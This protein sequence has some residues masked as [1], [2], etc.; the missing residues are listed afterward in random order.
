MEVLLDTSFIL[1]CLKEKIDFLQAGEY[2]KLI[3]PLQVI[4]ELRKKTEKGKAKERE[5]AKLA[6][7]IIQENKSNFKIIKLEKKFV[8]AG[9]KKYVSRKKKDAIVA[10]LDKELKK[11]IKDKANILVI[12]GRKKFELI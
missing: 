11:A 7:N 5:T 12:R 9:I 1:T 3:L 6:L 10:T 2:G 8:D 4:D